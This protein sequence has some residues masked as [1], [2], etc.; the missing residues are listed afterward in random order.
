[1]TLGRDIPGKQKLNS[2]Q[3]SILVPPTTKKKTDKLTAD[4]LEGGGKPQTERHSH[5]YSFPHKADPVTI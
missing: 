5:V 2:S 3:P 4:I 1:M